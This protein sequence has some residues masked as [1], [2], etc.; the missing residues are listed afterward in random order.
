[1]QTA[2]DLMTV[3]PSVTLRSSVK[4]ALA[5]MASTDAHA[6]ALVDDEE[7]LLGY[8]TLPEIMRELI[9]WGG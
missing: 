4:E 1:M 2:A 3:A 6:I 8:V 9:T 5:K 7:R